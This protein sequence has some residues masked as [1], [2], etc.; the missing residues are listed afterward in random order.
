[1]WLTHDAAVLQAAH[2]ARVMEQHNA[3]SSA[4]DQV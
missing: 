4:G 1:M 3:T 2:F